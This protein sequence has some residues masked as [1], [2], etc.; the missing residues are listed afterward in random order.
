M[1]SFM[2]AAAVQRLE[3]YFQQIGEVLGEESR[4]GSFALYAMGLL[5]DGERKSVEPIA[6]RACPNPERVDAMHQRLLH[7][8]VDSRWSDRDVRREASRYALEAMTRRE[9]VEA[10]IVDDTGFLK[11][12]KHSVGVQRQYTGSAGKVA[13]C[14]IGVSLS[15][16][17]RTE[18][19]PVDFEL[20]LPECWA[21]DEARR[22][23]ARIPAEV[24]FR[25]KPQLA[26]RMIER[27]VEDGVAPGVLL[28]DSAYGNSSGFRARLRAL[29][30]HYAVAVSAQTT[31]G[32]L[33][34]KGRPRK[35]AR[36]VSDLA[37]RIH[38]RGGFR[39]CTWRQGTQ[40]ALS[41]RFALRRVVAAGVHQ[42]EQ[43]PLGLLIEW[44][45]SE[46]EPANYFLISLPEGR[47]KK[48]LI[49]LVMQ[50]WRTERVYEDLKG[51]LGLD[52]YEGRRFPGWHHHVSVALCC[53]AFLVA[54]RTRR[55]P[56]SARRA[57]EA[58]TQ[59]LSA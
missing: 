11:Q 27:A 30:L 21:N 13:N 5:G 51:E 59:S 50:R 20:Y 47:T 7:F 4:R 48:Q 15:V 54:E 33:D 49:R 53:Y 35:D 6:A 43:E 26:L 24:S 55:F 56:P 44:R 52:H 39:R 37:W 17:T 9:S 22:R 23:E 40:E 1:D 10:W 14:Q 32:L 2:N 58:H 57:A 34:A 36:S 28:A 42:R 46:P 41:A 19:L 12:G 29:G 45:D 38:E 18:H 3:R 25:T 8:A 16:T 31:V